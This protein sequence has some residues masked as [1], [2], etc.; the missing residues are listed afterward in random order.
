[1]TK[2]GQMGEE[3]RGKEGRVGKG[4]EGEIEQGINTPAQKYL[5]VIP[6]A[7]V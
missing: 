6:Y 3:H 4:K 5:L 7:A 2:Q 1:M